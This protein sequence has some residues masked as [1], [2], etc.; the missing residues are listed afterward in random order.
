MIKVSM[1]FSFAMSVYTISAESQEL[2]NFNNSQN[3][4]LFI[5]SPKN[6]IY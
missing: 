6:G 2:W 4:N 1:H 3:E 5:F